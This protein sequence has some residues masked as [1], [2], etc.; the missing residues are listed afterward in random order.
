MQGRSILIIAMVLILLTS[1]GPIEQQVA[2]RSKSI[3]TVG[4]VYFSSNDCPHCRRIQNEIRRIQR[5]YPVKLR[6]FNID[7]LKA[8]ELFSKLESIHSTE[9]FGVP[10]IMLGDSILMGEDEIKKRLEPT[11]RRLMKSG[12]SP[13]PYLGPIASQK[14][15][16]KELAPKCP[17]CDRRPPTVGEEWG[18]VRTFID[19]IF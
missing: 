5:R 4:I 10:L 13:L 11:V 16:R 3:H 8:Y 2:A 9:G 15:T 12:G 17:N 19:R 1:L 7:N 18:K 6:S 14:R